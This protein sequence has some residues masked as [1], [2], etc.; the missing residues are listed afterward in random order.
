[1]ASIINKVNVV[2]RVATHGHNNNSN[3]NDDDDIS[4]ST[5]LLGLGLLGGLTAWYYYPELFSGDDRKITAKKF[6]NLPSHPIPK[7]EFFKVYLQVFLNSFNVSK[8]GHHFSCFR[9]V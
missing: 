8:N 4:I 7:K 3:N 5:I 2:S 6:S 9:S 1:M